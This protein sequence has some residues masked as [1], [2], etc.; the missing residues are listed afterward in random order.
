MIVMTKN[1]L[2]SNWFFE[3]QNLWY[4]DEKLKFAGKDARERALGSCIEIIVFEIFLKFFL[5]ILA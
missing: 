4:R 5:K 2:K 1:K 3:Q